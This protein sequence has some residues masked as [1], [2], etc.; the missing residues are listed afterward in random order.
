[1]VGEVE[2][3]PWSVVNSLV[4]VSPYM[5]QRVE[6]ALQLRA[7]TY[8][9]W[10]IFSPLAPSEY[11]TYFCQVRSALPELDKK[12][13]TSIAVRHSPIYLLISYPYVR[14]A[15]CRIYLMRGYVTQLK[16][17]NKSTINYFP[18]FLSSGFNQARIPHSR[19]QRLRL[20]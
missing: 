10:D 13:F 4:K 18:V 6:I 15:R 12:V 1:M 17:N 7:E 14:L 19:R 20:R 11:E 3:V 9:D 8:P 16:L 5:L 2:H